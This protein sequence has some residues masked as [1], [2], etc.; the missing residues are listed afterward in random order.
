MVVTFVEVT[1]AWR[2]G[3]S[4]P[5]SQQPFLQLLGYKL[6]GKNTLKDAEKVVHNYS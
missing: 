4:L 1:G 3:A 6:V 2:G 5:C